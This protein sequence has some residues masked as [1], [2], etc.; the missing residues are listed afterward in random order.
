MDTALPTVGHAIWRWLEFEGLNAERLF[1]AHGLSKEEL[2]SQSKRIPS[3]T[4]DGI[5]TDA[6]GGFANTCAGLSAAQ[7]WHPSDLGAMGYAWLASSTLGTAFRRME[8]YFAVVGE[9]TSVTLKDAGQGL[10]VSITQNRSDPMLRAFGADFSMSILLDMCRVNYH[11]PLYPAEVT[12]QR[13]RPNCASEYTKFYQ[14]EVYFESDEDSFTLAAADVDR[15]LP[16]SNRQLAGVHD[17][18]LTQQLAALHKDDIAARCKVIILENLTTGEISTEGVARELHMS[19]RTLTRRLEAQGTQLQKILDETRC[20]LA[21]RYF[22]DP[23][24]SVSEVAFLLGFSQQSSL[25][26]ASKRW[27]GMPPLKYRS[28]RATES[29]SLS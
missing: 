14:C 16:T 15:L 1:A 20:E 10:Q 24:N 2:Q 29:P 28:E 27:F 12:L 7:C 3:D 19:S 23:A 22:A 4:W 13:E 17:Q 6:S 5:M 9:R 21:E 18:I 26:R 8:R 11:S 25:T